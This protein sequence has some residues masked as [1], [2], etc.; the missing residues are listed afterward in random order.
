MELFCFATHF[1]VSNDLAQLTSAT[2]SASKL[3]VAIK[4]FFKR[5][6]TLK[7]T[8]FAAHNLWNYSFVFSLVVCSIMYIVLAF[9][10]FFRVVYLDFLRCFCCVATKRFH[11]TQR[12]FS[13]SLLFLF[14][15]RFWFHVYYF[16]HMLHY[17]RQICLLQLGS[18]NCE[19][20]LSEPL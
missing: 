13:A 17:I 2:I 3:E 8:F 6:A 11:K 15:L 9:S 1:G 16:R 7:A 4:H 19:S 5:I 14:C 12:W 18:N 20:L 10:H